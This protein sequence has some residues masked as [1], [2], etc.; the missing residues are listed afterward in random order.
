MTQVPHSGYSQQS[1]C[2]C[3]CHVFAQGIET[4]SGGPTV[5]TPTDRPSTEPLGGT[6]GQPVSDAIHNRVALAIHRTGVSLEFAGAFADLLLRDTELLDAL[7]TYRAVQRRAAHV[8]TSGL[9]SRLLD[10]SVAA[11][12]AEHHWPADCL[13]EAAEVIDSTTTR[14]KALTAVAHEW[15]TQST[16]YDEDTEQRIHDGWTLLEILDNPTPSTDV[17]ALEARGLAAMT[18]W[19]TAGSDIDALTDITEEDRS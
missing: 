18:E 6:A 5:A 14:L 15:A 4:P 2:G 12:K 16:D 8:E 10:A 7:V 9:G 17:A 19:R 13:A 3:R 11:R 1:P